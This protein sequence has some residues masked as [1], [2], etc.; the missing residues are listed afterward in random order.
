ME[1]N[2]QQ[3]LDT[4]KAKLDKKLHE[5]NA[6]TDLLE[7]LETKTGV[8][9]LYLVHGVGVFFGLYLMVGCG[10][11]FLCNFVGFLYPAYASIKAIESKETDDDTKRLTYWVIYSAFSLIE[12]FSDIFLFWIPF[13][14][15]FKCLFLLYCMIPAKWNGSVAIYNKVIKPWFCKHQKKIDKTLDKAADVAQ[16]VL[17]EAEETAKEAAGEAIK[18][19]YIGDSSKS[20]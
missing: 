10:A 2:V 15:F 14:F 6:L 5:E 1:Q 7:K 12:V 16:D 11:A 4:W 18:K 20:D 17:D 19:Q 13:H 9:R 3:N 8:R